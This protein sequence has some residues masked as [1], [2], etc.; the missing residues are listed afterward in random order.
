MDD[1]FIK[2]KTKRRPIDDDTASES[3]VI[4]GNKVFLINLL[5]VELLVECVQRP[6]QVLPVP[7]SNA[8]P[9]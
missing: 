1:L 7:S 5:A 9:F 3:G 8:F 4:D 6:Y 2:P